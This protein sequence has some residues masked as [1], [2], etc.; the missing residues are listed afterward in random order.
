[1][2]DVRTV[3]DDLVRFETVLWGTVDTRLRSECGISL[4]SLNVMLVVDAT[5]RCRV[6]DIAEA[7][8]ITVG[9]T[10]QAVDRLEAGNWCVRRANPDDRRSSIIELTDA[11]QVL[12]ASAGTVFDEEL[13]R[14]I[15]APLSP[16]AFAR[17][18]DA[19]GIV[20]RAAMN[21]SHDDTAK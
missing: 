16:S 3:F 12:L 18:G 4:A 9:G 13:D 7:L 6:F 1:M 15:R 19:L 10:S 2:T 20:R 5:A 8:A 11:G 14:L 21:A 17:L